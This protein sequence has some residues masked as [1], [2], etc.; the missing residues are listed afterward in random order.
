[1]SAGHVD[2]KNSRFLL[3]GGAFNSRIN[4]KKTEEILRFYN[5]FYFFFL[6][7]YLFVYKK[8]TYEMLKKKYFNKNKK[9]Q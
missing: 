6:F 8:F 4:K 5:Y 2:N 1:M 9:I 3:A 7:F